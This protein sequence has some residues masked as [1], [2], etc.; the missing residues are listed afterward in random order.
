MT[1]F[2][3]T[4]AFVCAGL[5]AVSARQTTSTPP[6]RTGSTLGGLSSRWRETG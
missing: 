4:A 5:A 3:L 2:V 1:R 6:G